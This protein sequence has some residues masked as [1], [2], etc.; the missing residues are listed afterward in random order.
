MTW[1]STREALS[2]FTCGKLLIKTSFTLKWLNHSTRTASTR[3]ASRLAAGVASTYAKH[4]RISVNTCYLSTTAKWTF[5]CAKSVNKRSNT[6]PT[7]LSTANS[8]CQVRLARSSWIEG[9]NKRSKKIEFVKS[10]FFGFYLVPSAP[11]AFLA[12]KSFPM[13]RS[14]GKSSSIRCLLNNFS[15]KQVP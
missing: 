10:W 2:T 6:V 1:S 3:R 12:I 11:A 7:W 8:T 15:R 9:M 13:K 4:H 5:I 14:T